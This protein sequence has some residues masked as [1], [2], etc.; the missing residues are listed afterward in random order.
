MNCVLLANIIILKMQHEFTGV[1]IVIVAAQILS[2]FFLLYYFS[3]TLETDVI[4][5]FMEE[6]VASK[7][8]WLGCFFTVGS[9]W[10][11]DHMLKSMR[12]CLA[13]CFAGGKEAKAK[14]LEDHENEM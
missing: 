5:R 6:F 1:N 12:L 9:L 7:P 13:Y 2:F 10:T 11:I 8:A 14:V 4:Y 3:M